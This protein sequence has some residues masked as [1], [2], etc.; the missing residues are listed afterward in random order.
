METFPLRY[1]WLKKGYDAAEDDGDCS[2]SFAS[3]SAI[4]RFGVGKNMVAAIR[5][6]AVAAGVLEEREGLRRSALGQMIFADAG[7]D[8][9]MGRTGHIVACTLAHCRPNGAD[10]VVLGVQPLLCPRLRAR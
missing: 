1:G 10:H 8:P 2:A 7:L 3:E 5:Y 9:W 6:W 4:A